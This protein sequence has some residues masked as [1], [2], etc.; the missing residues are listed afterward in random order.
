MTRLS[1]TAF[2]LLSLAYLAWPYA[3]LWQLNQ[4]LVR[5]DRAAL[6]E[7]VDIEAVRAAITR[8]LNGDLQSAVGE[9]SNRFVDWLQEG[10]R[11]SG[12]RAVERLVTLDWVWTQILSKCPPDGE[13]GFLP[14]VGYAFFEAYDH[15][16]VRIGARGQAPVYVL[17]RLKGF[18]WRVSAVYY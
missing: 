12:A 6:T 4:A 9:V 13:G 18:E 5:D 1:F 14:Q 11:H 3:V 17:L 16:L 10:I 8:K 2:L 7:L 15:F